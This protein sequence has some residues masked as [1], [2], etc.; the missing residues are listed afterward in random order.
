MVLPHGEVPLVLLRLSYDAKAGIL[1]RC[2][3]MRLFMPGYTCDRFLL[4][5]PL[6]AVVR[7]R[8]EPCLNP[9][10]SLGTALI[11][12]SALLVSLGCSGT[13][14]VGN[15]NQTDSKDTSNDNGI[16][17]WD[18]RSDASDSLFEK[19]EPGVDSADS[20]PD[21][22]PDVEPLDTNDTQLPDASDVPDVPDVPDLPDIPDVPDIQVDEIEEVTLPDTSCTPNCFQ[23]ECGSDGCQGVCGYCQYGYL[24]N[25][26]KCVSSVC[27]TQ[28]SLTLEGVDTYKE[29]GSNGCNGYC[30]FCLSG[31]YCGIEGLCY[32]G[33]CSGSCD[34]RECGDDGCG[35]S[36]GLCAIGEMCNDQYQCVPDPCGD[37]TYKAKCNSKYELVEC[38]DH[39]LKT[40]NCKSLP[41]KMCGWDIMVGKFDCITEAACVPQCQFEDG[42][43]K[44]CGEDGC[45]DFCGTCP[46]GWGCATGLCTPA[47]GAEC[48]WIDSVVGMC[49]GDI[50]WFCSAGI[51]YKY[52]CMAKE[53]KHCG[54]KPSANGGA[55][56]NACID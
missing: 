51:L 20:K 3:E 15:N 44:E 5:R 36:C 32:S 54:W 46:N 52:D 35:H 4:P 28:C 13:S 39:E 7:L 30:G 25:Q 11:L 10:L 41:N 40:T 47:P 2:Q 12:C 33:S 17:L 6:S 21:S 27:E 26:G 45:W 16:I 38:L 37:V 1:P 56:G 23:K 9:V 55:G 48:A 22:E 8:H 50:R 43:A 14:T 31:D 19:D 49:E 18:S 42:T 34:G 29:C 24:C 53:N